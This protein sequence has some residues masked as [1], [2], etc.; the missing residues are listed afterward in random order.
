MHTIMFMETKLINKHIITM[1][2][3][4]KYV[5]E[6]K[7]L[8]FIENIYKIEEPVNNIKEQKPLMDLLTDRTYPKGWDTDKS[9]SIVETLL[10]FFVKEEEYE[11]CHSI[12]QVWPE[13]LL[14]A[15]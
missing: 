10:H 6:E 13:I 7:Y 5:S 15:K 3:Q 9:L 4:L 12:T 14:T 1:S 8:A 2:E 11:L